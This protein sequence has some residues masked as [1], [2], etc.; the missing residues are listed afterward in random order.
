[1]ALTPEQIEVRLKTLE[2][3]NAKLEQLLRSGRAFTDNPLALATDLDDLG[4]VKTHLDFEE[5]PLTP[6][7]PP[8]DVLRLSALD[9]PN[10]AS[11]GHLTVPSFVDSAGDAIILDSGVYNPTLTNQTNVVGSTAF[12]G[13]WLR[14][15]DVVTVSGKFN[16]DPTSA[17]ILTQLGISIPVASNFTAE[18][19]CGG[20]VG[21]RTAEGSGLVFGD[22]TNDRAF[23]Q[24]FPT[25]PNNAAWGF[26]F[27]YRVI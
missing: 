1:M 11:G 5:P 21:C 24:F 8:A 14:V 22:A 25:S 19:H 15:G 6:I 13:Q 27:M 23:A 17:N 18:Q 7:D 2:D 16:C 20:S 9:G 26:I 4:S 10:T 3:R 12:S